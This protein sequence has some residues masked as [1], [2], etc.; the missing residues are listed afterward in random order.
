MA[1]PYRNIYIPERTEIKE[2]LYLTGDVCLFR[3]ESERPFEYNPG[4]FF[5]VSLW[6]AGEVP[7]S[8]ASLSDKK[9]EI[10]F[11]IRRAGKVTSAIHELQEGDSLWIRGPY[12]KAF[13]LEYAIG[14]DML[15]VGGGIGLAPLR[16]VLQWG[17]KNKNSIKKLSLLYGARTPEDIIFKEDLQDWAERGINVVLTVDRPNNGWDGNV[18]L[19]TTLWHKSEIDFKDA[20]SFICGPEV[21]IKAAIKDLFFFGMPE[22]RI[23]TTL[24]AH[25]KCGVG[26]CGHCYDGEKY[27]CTDGPVFT[28]KE[29][30]EFDLL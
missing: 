28:Y 17:L 21:M 4:Q 3:V 8:V 22:E 6:G 18:G 5:M 27:I 10:E 2:K 1:R 11:C 9:R 29:I 14:R 25:M 23:I 20:V 26:K 13:P 19:V 12:G 15:I 7:I 24:E 16:P 30:K